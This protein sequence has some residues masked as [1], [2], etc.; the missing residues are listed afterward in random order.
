MYH[1]VREYFR[2]RR[3]SAFRLVGVRG[4]MRW[5]TDSRRLSILPSATS[6]FKFQP[7]C[8]YASGAQC[9]G[10]RSSASNSSA[11]SGRLK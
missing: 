3:Y 4:H 10:L 6:T 1:G 11:G 9:G 8:V 7:D 5:S 2:R